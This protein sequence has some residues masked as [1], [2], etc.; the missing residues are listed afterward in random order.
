M[1][2]TENPTAI[3]ISNVRIFDI[4]KSGFLYIQETI[5]KGAS[6]QDERINLLIEFFPFVFKKLPII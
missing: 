4:P 3:G 2:S 5:T 6:T 1:P